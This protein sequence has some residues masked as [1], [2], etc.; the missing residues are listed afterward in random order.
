MNK[1]DPKN[2]LERLDVANCGDPL[3]VHLHEQRYELAIRSMGH[4]GALLEIGT[5]LGVFSSRVAPLAGSY[6]GVEY[7]HETCLK[8]KQRVANPDWI[9]QGDAQNLDMPDSAF[10]TVICL[11][12]LEHLPNYR[13]ALDEI[14]RVLRPG[15]RFIAS[16][17]YAEVGAPSNTNPHHL[18]EPGEDEFIAEI[19]QRFGDSRFLYH[20]YEERGFETF[21]RKLKLRRVL[22]LSRQYARISEGDPGEMKKVVLDDVKSG[23]LLGLFAVAEKPIK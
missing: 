9:T 13:K 11:E 1:I 18:Y 6:K 21:A 16:I 3:Q 23:M 7:D 15:G 17:P 22:G 8:A 2:V 12:V 4:P 10:D 19:R 20:R 14:V 5:G